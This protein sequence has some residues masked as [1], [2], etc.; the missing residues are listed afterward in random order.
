MR[1]TLTQPP[2]E[3]NTLHRNVENRRTNTNHRVVPY[4]SIHN[5]TDRQHCATSSLDD[6]CVGRTGRPKQRNR[7]Q[8]S[9]FGKASVKILYAPIRKTNIGLK[10]TE[11]GS[12]VNERAL[13]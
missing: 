2:T 7:A 12:V 3:K 8:R 13:L 4:E 6:R 1:S 9:A 5:T 10:E 11:A